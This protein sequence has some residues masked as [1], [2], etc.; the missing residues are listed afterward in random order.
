MESQRSGQEKASPLTQ[1][2]QRVAG[3]D[4]TVKKETLRLNSTA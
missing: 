1:A 2:E 4:A 3:L